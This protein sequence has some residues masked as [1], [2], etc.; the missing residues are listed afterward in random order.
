M[1]QFLIR[2][3]NFYCLW[4]DSTRGIDMT[5]KRGPDRV[6]SQQR[7]EIQ[8]SQAKQFGADDD[9]SGLTG[10]PYSTVQKPRAERCWRYSRT[11]VLYQ[12]TTCEG[13]RKSPNC[14]QHS[15]SIS[16]NFIIQATIS[17][18]P[19]A[20]RMCKIIPLSQNTSSQFF[21]SEWMVGGIA[22]PSPSWEPGFGY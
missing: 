4:W 5:K 10:Q 21:S 7:C 15:C 17:I 9:L 14:K 19:F 20:R 6:M 1:I 2:I 3:I 12:Q 22:T 11:Q 8:I 16:I 13:R 18:N